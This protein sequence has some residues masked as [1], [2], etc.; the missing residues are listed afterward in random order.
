MDAGAC[1]E[2][3]EQYFE[4]ELAAISG[5]DETVIA[6]MWMELIGESAMRELDGVE[7][8]E[9]NAEVVKI[10][11][12]LLAGCRKSCVLAQ[13]VVTAL[14]HA[15][16]PSSS[17]IVFP[18][19][20]I[21]ALPIVADPLSR[22]EELTVELREHGDYSRIR[23][24]WCQLSILVNLQE[25]LAPAFRPV[26]NTGKK[27]GDR[28]FKAIHRDRIVIDCHWLRTTQQK[29]LIRH[30]DVEF[31]PLFSTAK[32]FPFELAWD[33]AGREWKSDHRVVDMLRLTEF[34]QY[35]LAALREDKVKKR[36]EKIESGSRED[37]VFIPAPLSVFEQGL[38]TWCERDKRIV[39]YRDAYAAVWRARSFLGNAAPVRQVGELAA[40]MLGAKRKDDKSIRDMEANIIRHILET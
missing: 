32:P 26:L 20:S 2:G 10:A 5:L 23:D 39:R 25:A 8:V 33:F 12:R 11:D 19:Y 22:L 1:E 29:V 17:A 38:N 6:D 30:K 36:V 27:Y 34:Q 7:N 28:V 18:V 14:R 4:R 13:N 24:E 15:H 37:K 40:W 9:R 16:E 35:Q 3:W 31:R 21:E